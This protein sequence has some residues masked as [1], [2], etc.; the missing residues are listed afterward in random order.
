MSDLA[1]ALENSQ[2]EARQNANDAYKSKAQ[3]D[4]ANE[5]IEALRRE[6]KNLSGELFIFMNVGIRSIIR[7]ELNKKT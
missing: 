7:R 2:K 1:G 4:E 5:A 6:N 3:L